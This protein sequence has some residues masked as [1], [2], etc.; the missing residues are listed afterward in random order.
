MCP[1]PWDGATREPRGATLGLVLL[2]LLLLWAGSVA[3]ST[4]AYPRPS[5]GTLPWH[6]A[7]T[8]SECPDP[9]AASRV[10]LGAA[11]QGPGVL[12][13]TWHTCSASSTLPSQGRYGRGGLGCSEL[14]C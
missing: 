9:A 11:R 2:L 14:W 3:L 1:G 12:V 7:D 6:V 5:C 13:G 10:A 4:L 8:C